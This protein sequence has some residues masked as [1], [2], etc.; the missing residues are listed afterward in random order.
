MN[1]IHPRGAI[2]PGARSHPVD[3]SLHRGTDMNFCYDWTK[4]G[5]SHRPRRA[6]LLNAVHRVC[7]ALVL[8]LAATLCDAQPAPAAQSVRACPAASAPGKLSCG[9]RRLVTP[10]AMARAAT[11]SSFAQPS[12]YAPVDLQ[13]AYQVT[14]LV[15]SRGM[16]RTLATTIAFDYPNA[17]ADLAVYRA[18]FGLPPCTTA[19]GCFRK[20]NDNGA[21]SPLPAAPPANDDW[22][23]E[24]AVDLQMLSALCPNC[25]L[26]LVEA[27]SDQ[28]LSLFVA[29]STAAGL[30]GV[31]AVEMPWGGPEDGNGPTYC[32][33][34]F[35][36]P[37]IAMAAAS[38]DDGFEGSLSQFPSS[39]RYVTAVG[40]TTLTADATN[41]RGWTETAWDQSG[42]VCARTL[43]KPVWQTDVLCSGRTDSDIAADADPNTGVAVYNAAN[44]GW[45]VLG[46]QSTAVSIITGLYG[47]AAPAQSGD[48]P[49]SYAYANPAAFFDITSGT[50]GP[51]AGPLC[52]AGVGFDGPTGLGTPNGVAGLSPPSASDFAVSVSPA[53]LTVQQGATGTASVSTSI[54][55]GSAEA[56][57]LSVSGVPTGA[58]AT[59]NPAAVT[60]GAS[61]TLSVAAGTAAPGSYSL[62]VTATAS[63]GSHTATLSLIVQAPP[64]DFAI[65]ATPAALTIAQ[66]S[67]A[68]TTIGTSVVSG[69]PETINLT[70]VGL[71]LGASGS[72]SSSAIG[73]GGSVT[74]AVMAGTAAP[75]TYLLIVSGAASSATHATTVSLTITAPVADFTLALS[76]TSRIAR[77]PSVGYF[78][79]TVSALHGFSAPVK[80]SVNG[81]PGTVLATVVPATVTG[82][83][84]A[85]L[86]YFVGFRQPTGTLPFTVTG[87]SGTLSHSVTGQLTIQ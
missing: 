21:A 76:P 45:I 27:G 74:L 36:H 80:L 85:V 86:L 64:N 69:S 32:E 2:A 33:T 51:C 11:V 71:P 22:T 52:H 17:E 56:L 84:N 58:T 73:S 54:V 78:T 12:G 24:G 14:T 35:N 79:V 29:Q 40:G 8:V 61:A 44:G 53:S 13:S 16:G 41:P 49:V 30:P 48:Y 1:D 3:L 43:P 47:L 39:C 55:L 23:V 65:A 83:G 18:Q 34:Q 68:S 81:L 28:D 67:S 20:L 25:N 87:V 72:L 9:A 19:N 15:G 60:T 66:G 82:S 4:P 37:G 50:N 63:S 7:A 38:P 31:V 57:S 42:S 62:L 46:G 59:I 77:H 5:R 10:F 26:L 70:V 6:R 75:G